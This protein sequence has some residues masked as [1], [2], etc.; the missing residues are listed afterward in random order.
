MKP[1]NNPV[2]EVKAEKDGLD[3]L[4][5]IEELAATHGGWETL[6]AED[7]KRLK[8][9]GTFFRKPTSG[10]FMM[11]IRVTNGQTTSAQL[12]ALAEIAQR[13]GNGVLDIT[14]RQQVQLR[15]IKIASVPEILEALQGVDLN[16]FQTGMDNIRGVNSCPLSGLT[17]GELFDASPVG[18]EYTGI[19]LKNKEFTNLP[20]KFNVTIIGCL[21]N[22]TH[23]ETQDLGMS[24]AVRESGGALG[25][26]V[27]VGGKMGSGGMVAATPLEIFVEPHE[28]ARLAAEMTLLFR[29]KGARERRTKT[30]FAFLIEEWGAERFPAAQE[31]RGASPFRAQDGTSAAPQRPTTWAST[32]R[33]NRACRPWACASP[34]GG[35]APTK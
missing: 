1:G 23:G 26:N 18:V 20:R 24:P 2:E 14:T 12:R 19:F 29:H 32:R 15:A 4:D 34:P 35:P 13:L 6:D 17:A 25:F 31:D 11:R 7:R 3:I 16:S 30:R 5:E 8:W 28:A 27:F 9:I 22:C 21:E 33:A 10:Q